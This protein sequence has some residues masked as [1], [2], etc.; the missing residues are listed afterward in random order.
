M[1]KNIKY[2]WN[3]TY[4]LISTEKKMKRIWKKKKICEEL[5]GKKNSDENVKYM[6]LLWVWDR[7]VEFSFTSEVNKM[8]FQ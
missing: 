4:T 1:E 7:S 2:R 6:I 3:Y 8:S 5:I